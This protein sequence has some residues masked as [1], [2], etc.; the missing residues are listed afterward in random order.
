V[1][2]LPH[3]ERTDKIK[4]SSVS[5]HLRKL[6]GRSYDVYQDR[7]LSKVRASIRSVLAEKR[8]GRRAIFASVPQEAEELVY[9]FLSDNYA[10]PF[11]SWEDSEERKLLS[12]SGFDLDGVESIIEHCYRRL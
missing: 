11:M 2:S 7:F 1:P 9:S 5:D 12:G 3:I 6:S 8:F 10:N 4:G